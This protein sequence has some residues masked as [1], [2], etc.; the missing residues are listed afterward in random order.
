[1]QVNPLTHAHKTLLVAQ[2]DLLR[3]TIEI[4]L[5][6]SEYIITNALKKEVDDIDTVLKHNNIDLVIIQIDDHGH[7]LNKFLLMLLKYNVKVLFITE[8][9]SRMKK[10]IANSNLVQILKHPFE[11]HALLTTLHKLCKATQAA[12]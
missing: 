7:T 4:W 9:K 12:H 6:R 8:N 1:M 3:M 10:N 2:D 5:Y 11:Y